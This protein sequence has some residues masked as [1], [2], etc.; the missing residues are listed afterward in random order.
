MLHILKTTIS[1]LR[2]ILI[3]SMISVYASTQ[4]QTEEVISLSRS[5]I[6]TDRIESIVQ[7]ENT[8][9]DYSSLIADLQHYHENPINLNGENL[10]ALRDLMLLSDHQLSNIKSYRTLVGGFLSV[11]ELRKVP[12][13]D[14][15]SIQLILPFINISEPPEAKKRSVGEMFKYARQSLQIRYKQ[16]LEKAKGFEISPDSAQYYPG[17][18]YLGKPQQWNIKYGFQSGNTIRLGFNVEKDA[19]EPW[20]WST[21][22]DSISVLIGDAKN[23]TPDYLSFFA[24]LSN[25]GIIKTLIIGDYKLEF[26]QGLTLWS[27]LS[28]GKS[29]ETVN[30]QRFGRGVRPNTS[31]DENSFFRGVALCL[32][33]KGLELSS[34]A[35]KQRIDGKLII[36]EDS[37][38]LLSS[39]PETGM[40]RTLNELKAKDAAELT[41]YGGNL[42]A[43]WGLFQLGIT[44]HYIELSF[45]LK[46][47][48]SLYQKHQFSG[49]RNMVNGMDFNLRLQQISM[50]GEFSVSANGA[51]AYLM[52][53]NT[54]LDDRISLSALYHSY[55]MN[56]Q[57]IFSNPFAQGSGA[58]NERG[59]YLGIKALLN[60]NWILSAYIDSYRFPWLKYQVAAPSMAKDVLIQVDHNFSQKSHAYFKYRYKFK[61]SNV[62]ENT[63]YMPKIFSLH[64][65]EFRLF[66]SYQVTAYLLLKNR[67]DYV[68]LNNTQDDSEQ[69]FLFY[70]DILYRPSSSRIQA[71]FRY[72][73]FQT[74]SYHSRIY[75]YENDVLYAFSIPAFYDSGQRIY[76]MIKYAACDW[77][78]LWIR[79]ARLSYFNRESIGTGSEM[80]KG[81]SRTEIK[82]QLQI[83]L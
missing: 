36:L 28:F 4:G 50:Y 58:A 54:Y 11:Y 26:G 60:K 30:I 1:Q 33:W 24:Q 8:A 16:N 5:E 10:E 61:E 43:V 3:L 56:Y 53:L 44:T 46:P 31:T 71:T 65:H 14:L 34:F 21:Y 9:Y 42:K 25:V 52:G 70:Q 79:L 77:L 35:S 66:F 80:T 2:F 19:G 15:G 18:I 78:N 81:N 57:N 64:R 72:A 55:Q 51:Y 59:F 37:S 74:D 39:L 63:E 17:S 41:A 83:K 82:C 6:L 69:G 13:M 67:L 75:A 23:Y 49:I 32:Q 62:S 27:G 68:W 47:G 73:I 20:P 7:S 45:A 48:N 76:L 22:N 38:V 29:A 12:G 40:H